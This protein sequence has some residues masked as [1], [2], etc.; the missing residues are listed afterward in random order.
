[1]VGMTKKTPFTQQTPAPATPATPAPSGLSK[2]H[3]PAGSL[4]VHAVRWGL[5]LGALAL[6]VGTTACIPYQDG[7]P[8]AHQGGGGQASSSE[9]GNEGAEENGNGDS[10]SDQYVAEAPE[11]LSDVGPP[12]WDVSDAITDGWDPKLQ[13]GIY[14]YTHQTSTCVTTLH[15]NAGED[16]TSGQEGD[17]QS[18]I[19][20]W[21]Q[22]LEG[23]VGPVEV[24]PRPVVEV[25]NHGGPAQFQV[26][27]L[28][29][30]DSD[31]VDYTVRM[32]AQWFELSELVM[33]FSCE[34]GDFDAQSSEMEG[35]LDRLAVHRNV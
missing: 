27:D 33:A 15:S 6:A 30:T 3:S 10:D 1:M 4:R 11:D 23:E 32:F 26:A 7:G 28:E 35:F 5:G 19:D 2:A 8:E 31:G 16:N 24:T 29:Y 34:P 22:S 20:S 21:A 14:T 17:P 25:E 12:L 18:S 13:D 9:A